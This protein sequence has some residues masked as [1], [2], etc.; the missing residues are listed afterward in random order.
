[1]PEVIFLGCGS[2]GKTLVSRQIIKHMAGK[3]AASSGRESK[4]Q[5]PRSASTP[6]S[7]AGGGG[8]KKGD[9]HQPTPALNVMTTPTTGMQFETVHID[10]QEIVLREVGYD[11][12]RLWHKYYKKADVLLYVVD[13]SNRAQLSKASVCLLYTSPSPRDRG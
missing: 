7:G 2:V 6:R 8:G 4:T 13:A 12:A 11:M 3:A 5:S 9:P 1:M 10:G